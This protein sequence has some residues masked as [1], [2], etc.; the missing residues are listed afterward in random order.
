MNVDKHTYG[1]IY[2]LIKYGD[3]YLKLFKTS[4][5][6]EDIL[7]DTEEN[8]DNKLNESVND[9]D[10]KLISETIEEL[11]KAQE[12]TKLEEDVNLKVS[13]K[14]DH[15]V[16]Y[17]EAV[18]NPGEMFELT[19]FGKTKGYIK[20][21]AMIQ[22]VT[23][24][25]NTYNPLLKYQ[26]NKKDVDVYQATSFVHACLEDNS[27]RTPEEVNIFVNTSEED[28]KVGKDLSY[29]VKRGQSLLYNSFKI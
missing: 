9:D 23:D 16:H 24:T 22:N 2:S 19:K 13:S 26:M 25:G 8:K 3:L 17:I 10:F 6:D 27:S 5:Y 15:Y 14:N 7:F 29:T 20:A 18:P 1:W 4:D 28:E 12:K 21:P 11:Q